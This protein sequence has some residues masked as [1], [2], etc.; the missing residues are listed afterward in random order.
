MRNLSTVIVVFAVAGLCLAEADTFPL[1]DGTTW[2][3]LGDSITTNYLGTACKYT[4]YVEAYY[5]LRFPQNQ[6]HFRGCGRGGSTLPEAIERFDSQVFMWSPDVVSLEMGH[7]GNAT[8]A[9]FETNLGVVADKTIALGAESVYLSLNPK[10]VM[11]GGVYQDQRADAFVTVGAARG[12]VTVDQFHHLLPLWEQNLTDPTPVDLDFV[13][14]VHPGSP[15]HL[16]MAWDVLKSLG[17]PAEVS[18]ARF[19]ASAGALV[20]SS[21]CSVSSVT[22]TT[23]GVSFTR[24]D[25]RLPIA[26]DDACR[27][28]LELV[29]TLLDDISAYM[30]QVDNLAP[31][32]YRIIIDGEECAVVS[33][34]QL[35]AGYN[36]SEM[37]DG[38]IYDQLQLV[39]QM[40]RQKEG[41]NQPGEMSVSKARSTATNYY[42]MGYRGDDLLNMVSNYIVGVDALDVA[43]HDASQPVAHNFEIELVPEPAGAVLLALGAAALIRRPRG[44]RHASTRT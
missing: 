15:G 3:F 31:G 7:N 41:D 10:Y 5:H 27:S 25:D 22:K 34:D 14:T 9:E 37:S 43:I 4:D 13:D 19:D 20:S 2:C 11:G 26:F 35:A 1:P 39:R 30:L 18:S 40:I 24:L 36:M 16:I 23:T 42:N 29:P 12:L 17:A 32:E 38:A 28:A 33:A 44:S 21:H 8:Q 6:Y